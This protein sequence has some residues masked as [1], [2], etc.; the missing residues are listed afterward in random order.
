M[1][2]GCSSCD[3]TYGSATHSSL[4]LPCLCWR[5]DGRARATETIAAGPS[6]VDRHRRGSLGRPTV[7]RFP[8]RLTPPLYQVQEVSV[9]P[10]LGILMK[11]VFVLVL[12]LRERAHQPGV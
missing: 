10:H 6:S 5:H 12:A 3:H 9:L 1:R 7:G 8:C 4:P 11:E 2:D